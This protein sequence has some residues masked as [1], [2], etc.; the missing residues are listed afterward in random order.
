MFVLLYGRFLEIWY[1]GSLLCLGVSG[2]AEFAFLILGGSCLRCFDDSVFGYLVL[3]V[4][5]YFG[6]GFVV[7]GWYKTEFSRNLALFWDFSF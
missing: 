6:C 3:R 4:I 2:F 1:F 7:W 5:C